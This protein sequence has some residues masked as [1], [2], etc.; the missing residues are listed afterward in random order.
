MNNT[1]SGRKAEK[2]NGDVPAAESLLVFS[3]LLE[4]LELLFQD[5]RV[6]WYKSQ[7]FSKGVLLELNAFDSPAYTTDLSQETWTATLAVGSVV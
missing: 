4:V 3:C 6:S 1:T 5:L 7:E 2:E